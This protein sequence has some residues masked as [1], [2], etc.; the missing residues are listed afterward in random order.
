MTWC[1][2]DR[3]LYWE[4]RRVD[5]WQAEA[6]AKMEARRFSQEGLRPTPHAAGADHSP[7]KA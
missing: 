1:T 2:D 5:A 6:K 3:R 7:G 4:Q